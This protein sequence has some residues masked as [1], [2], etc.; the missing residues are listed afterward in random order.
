L[1]LDDEAQWR[2]P[3]GAA[4]LL[5]LCFISLGLAGL[6]HSSLGRSLRQHQD[7]LEREPR[8]RSDLAILLLLLLFVNRH[9]PKD[10]NPREEYP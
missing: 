3:G 7:A 5:L 4:T 6:S 1:D 9:K 2:A 8:S 10:S